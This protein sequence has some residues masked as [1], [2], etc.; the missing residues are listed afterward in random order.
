[1]KKLLLC[2]ILCA[3]LIPSVFARSSWDDDDDFDSDKIFGIT[4]GI[5]LS[6]LGLEPTLAVDIY[7]L[8]IEAAMNNLVNMASMRASTSNG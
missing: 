1:M 3:G 4:P 2:L 6:I 7:H 8:E 5:R